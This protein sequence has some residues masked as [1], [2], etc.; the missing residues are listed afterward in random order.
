ML[1]IN[2]QNSSGE[3]SG[4]KFPL[5]GCNLSQNSFKIKFENVRFFKLFY[6]VTKDSLVDLTPIKTIQKFHFR[7]NCSTLKWRWFL[8]F[9]K[10]WNIKFFLWMFKVSFESFDLCFQKVRRSF[11]KD[12]IFKP[13]L[14]KFSFYLF[15]F[16]EKEFH[17]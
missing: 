1:L 3:E 10:I 12:L 6:K 5:E 11:W 15:S 16:C 7:L 13:F 4:I 2:H 8:K 17:R 9:P 14:L